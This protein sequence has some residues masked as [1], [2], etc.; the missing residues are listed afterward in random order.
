SALLLCSGLTSLDSQDLE[1]REEPLSRC[2]FERSI[3]KPA[4]TKQIFSDYTLF[5]HDRNF[6][7]KSQNFAHTSS[8]NRH[9]PTPPHSRTSSQ[10]HMTFT[11]PSGHD[12]PTPDLASVRLPPLKMEMRSPPLRSWIEQQRDFRIMTN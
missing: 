10:S 6:P 7:S 2:L 9:Y 4:P 8:A 5:R 1:E 3:M 12:Q 11:P